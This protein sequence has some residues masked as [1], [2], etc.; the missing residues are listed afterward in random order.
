[1]VASGRNGLV[2]AATACNCCVL[3]LTA[4]AVGSPYW[5]YI[6]SWSGGWGTGS[7]SAST[8]G[9]GAWCAGYNSASYS[10]CFGC[11]YAWSSQCYDWSDQNTNV[12]CAK[13][14]ASPDSCSIDYNAAATSTDLFECFGKYFCSSATEADFN[15]SE[16][17]SL[18]AFSILALIFSFFA[19][20]AGAA[21]MSS[22]GSAK[23]AALCSFLTM[24]FSIVAFSV[25]ASWDYAQALDDGNAGIPLLTATGPTVVVTNLFGYGPAF[26]CSVTAFVFSLFTTLMLASGSNNGGDDNDG[27][28]GASV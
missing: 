28:G 14:V 8:Y 24:I 11:F 27:G 12:I 23:A 26:G 22:P 15:P 2:G 18:Q 1:M 3:I 25:F 4:V 17:Q 5:M 13:Y 19:V 21:G 6:G 9:T 7:A 16:V 20:L 10:S